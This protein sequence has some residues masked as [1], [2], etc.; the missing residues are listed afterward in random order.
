MLLHVNASLK[1]H[2]TTGYVVL[3]ERQMKDVIDYFK[4]AS[5]M[6]HDM[7]QFK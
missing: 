6:C 7:L 1:K 2:I 5:N 3:L 4:Q